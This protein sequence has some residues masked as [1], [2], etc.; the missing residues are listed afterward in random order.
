MYLR[1]Y[2]CILM[3]AYLSMS[4]GLAYLCVSVSVC[5]FLSMVL[6]MCVSQCVS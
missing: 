2:S 3:Y 5:V 1:V 6:D 4:V